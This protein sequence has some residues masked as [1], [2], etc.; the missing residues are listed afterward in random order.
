MNGILRV[1]MAVEFSDKPPQNLW[2]DEDEADQ[3]P[4][5]VVMKPPDSTTLA[6]SQSRRLC[7]G[8]DVWR[9]Y[10]VACR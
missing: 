7:S 5:L 2:S 6:L 1:G 4:R 10:T 3:A 9:S 8:N